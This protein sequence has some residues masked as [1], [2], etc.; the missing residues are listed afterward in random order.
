[1]NNNRILWV[2]FFI[3][4]IVIH[5]QEAIASD[6]LFVVVTASYNNA[7]WCHQNLHSIFGQKYSNFHLIY[8]DDCST[9][10]TA[11]LV[12]GW[13]RKQGV[14][15]KITLIRNK[16]RLG[17]MANHYRAIQLIPDKAIVCIV[18]G[19]DWLAHYEVFNYLN[20]IY[21]SSDTWLTYG[22]FQSWPDNGVGWCVEI[23][24]TYVSQ[25][26]FREFERNLS[27]LRTFYAGLFKQIKKEDLMY[28]NL[29]LPMCADNAA[30]FP[31]AEMARGHIK[32]IS[33]VLLI[34]NGGSP[35]N[36]HKISSD[37]QKGMDLLVRKLPRY[38]RINTPFKDGKMGTVAELKEAVAAARQEGII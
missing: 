23:P 17:A 4:C 22:Q 3:C 12:E 35:I 16:E 19:D 15:D 31:M 30:M 6:K 27:H 21:S 13:A 1:M 33:K 11:H 5:T 14:Q 7:K 18:D 9:D 2:W 36:D 32:F 20:R 34:W 8:I 10:G 24:E 29:F 37:L 25:N 26:A 28:N 38:S